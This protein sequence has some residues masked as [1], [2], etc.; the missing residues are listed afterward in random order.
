MFHVKQATTMLALWLLLALLVYALA[1]GQR[2]ECLT[3]R[4]QAALPLALEFP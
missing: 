4:L 2:R 1:P 3:E